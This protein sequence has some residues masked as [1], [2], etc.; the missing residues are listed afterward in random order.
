MVGALAVVGLAVLL[1]WT[2]TARAHSLG[3]DP[4]VAMA[5][6]RASDATIPLGVAGVSGETV[7][8]SG[9]AYLGGHVQHVV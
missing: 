8:A 3:G 6:L 7:V 1:S 9:S 2:A 5:E 4:L